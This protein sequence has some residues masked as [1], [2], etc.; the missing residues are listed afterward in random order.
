MDL[1]RS[2]QRGWRNGDVGRAISL[3]QQRAGN[4]FPK[5]RVMA[6]AGYN[7]GSHSGKE[8]TQS[9]PLLSS[10]TFSSRP[11]STSLFPP[12]QIDLPSKRL[13]GAATASRISRNSAG[14][15]TFSRYFRMTPAR[16]SPSYS[17]R[18][19]HCSLSASRVCSSFC[20]RSGARARNSL[21]SSS[22]R[23][24]SRRTVSEGVDRRPIVISKNAR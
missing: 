2:H 11:C 14:R 15:P 20:T 17:P 19:G 5:L 9:S 10:A 21:S 4:P 16:S 24:S 6:S 13:A 12:S 22:R 18:S 7:C 1:L 8:S 3:K 23:S